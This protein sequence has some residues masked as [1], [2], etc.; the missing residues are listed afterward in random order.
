MIKLNS[1]P[2]IVLVAMLAGMS[3]CLLAEIDQ[4]EDMETPGMDSSI[5]GWEFQEDAV[6]L[7]DY[8]DFNKLLKVRIDASFGGLKYF[9]DPASIRIG[10]DDVVL[11]TVVITSSRGA[12]NVMFEAYRC[13]TREYKRI[14]YG[15]SKNEFYT[16]ADPQWEA[17]YRATGKAQD[18][19]RELL[20]TYLCNTHREPL[21]REEIIRL[22]KYPSFRDDSER[23]F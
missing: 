19:R 21:P 15:T 2:A 18:Y 5:E 8:P 7:P 13:D 6:N 1:I 17:A 16:L 14:A 4:L 11:L 12:K 23:M 3:P 10:R 22:I 9:I 20:T